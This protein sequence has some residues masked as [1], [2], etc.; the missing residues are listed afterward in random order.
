MR[1]L[2]IIVLVVGM[3]A[4][5]MVFATG[6]SSRQ[7]RAQEGSVTLEAAQGIGVLDPYKK[8]FQYSVTLY[9]LLWNTLTAYSQN[10][11]A[12]PRPQ[13]ATGWK[14]SAG[15][16][17]Y[18]FAIRPGA[19]FSDG[20]PINAAAVVSSLRR[21]FDPKTAFFY[22]G[23]FPKVTSVTAPTSSKVVIRLGTASNIL[24]TLLTLVPI[25]KTSALAEINTKPVV[26]GPFMVHSSH[27]TS[28]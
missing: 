21:A 15:G 28:L 23:F 4:S 1:R 12:V 13:L 27:R 9:P 11:G 22:A 16:K 17:V 8:L 7:A 2:A 24:P 5:A 3:V 6:A 14:T 25:I 19:Q 20:S 10:T 26:S 18:T